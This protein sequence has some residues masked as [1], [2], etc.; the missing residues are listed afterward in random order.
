MLSW[1][2]LHGV[3]W[4]MDK[5]P[6]SF[7]KYMGIETSHSRCSLHCS[8]SHDPSAPPI[9]LALHEAVQPELPVSDT[10]SG[11][12]PMDFQPGLG[13]YFFSDVYPHPTGTT[14]NLGQGLSSQS[15]GHG[16]ASYHQQIDPP[17]ADG[18]IYNEYAYTGPDYG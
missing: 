11:C 17:F 8:P 7:L 5:C 9:R 1:N 2:F 12:T 4:D 6:E 10:L 13:P 14:S 16:S 3:A 18:G 15:T